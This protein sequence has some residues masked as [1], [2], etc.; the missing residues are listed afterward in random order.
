[1]PS[2]SSSPAVA[3]VVP[4]AAS[5]ATNNGDLNNSID[6]IFSLSHHLDTPSSS[7]SIRPP[8][9]SSSTNQDPEVAKAFQEIC[10]A[11]RTGDIE[12]VDSLLSTPNLDI[13]Q[14]DEYDYSPLILSSLCGHYEIVELLLSRGAV[15]DRDTFQGARCIYGALT[16]EIRDLLVSFDI[17]KAIDLTQPFAGH[18]AS[19]LNPLLNNTLTNDIV[20]KFNQPG[21]SKDLKWF[22]L[23]RFLLVARS[24]YF[25]DKLL[26]DWN[27]LTVV[28]MPTSVDPLVFKRIVD[29]IYL[30]TDSIIG[31]DSL[32]IQDQLLTLAQ[33]YK[34]Y[35]LIEG[36]EEIQ[37]IKD[38]K[39][40]SKINHELSFKFVEK[41]RKDL[42]LFLVN[43]IYQ[44]KLISEMNLKQD[45]DLEDIDCHE[46]LTKSQRETLLES[47]SIPDVIIS[48]IDLDSESVIYYPVNKSIIAR[49]EYFDTMFK[50]EI[51]TTAEEELPLFRQHESNIEVIN[52][53]QI[54]IDH[55]PMIQI[56]TST[57]NQK[58]AEMVLSYLYHDDVH[59]IPLNLSIDLLFAADELFLERLKTMSAVNITSNFQRFTF[60]EM[61][62]LFNKL[63]YDGYDLIRASWQTRS[64]KLEQHIT[65][66]MAYN[67]AEIFNDK[68][69]RSNFSKLIKESA[70]RIKE[71]QDTDTIELID[72][73][74]YYLAKKYSIN[75]ETESFDPTFK[76]D[77]NSDDI[78]LYK[79]ALIQYEKDIEIIDYLLD[80]LK[81]DA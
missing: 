34:L 63:D 73:I 44:E 27:G 41:A 7:S 70:E 36:I 24:P 49:S 59:D 20:F 75:Q 8:E 77:K 15:C 23:H 64:D 45:I 61:K 42:D 32:L 53:P 46:F 74:R 58:V 5:T 62:S 26:N 51:F 33:K 79:S 17:S 37:N 80:L 66:M 72:D 56:S 81:L 52:R 54:D 40:K 13:N 69:E 55:I 31:D 2:T 60:K 50:S 39:E 12:V 11:C 57:S 28:N 19:L 71:R 48:C 76:D 38:E 3:A 25:K 1:M 22:N 9:S 67:L 18:I 10:M 6:L 78:N 29:Y 16:D 30:R 47:N 68:D 35:D 43:N 14:V 4:V 65:K 21:L